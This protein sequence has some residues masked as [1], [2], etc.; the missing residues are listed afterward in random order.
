MSATGASFGMPVPLVSSMCSTLQ[1]QV[2]AYDFIV[3]APT[4]SNA[5]VI[6]SPMSTLVRPASAN[7]MYTKLGVDAPS[8][9]VGSNITIV[10]D[11]RDIFNNSVDT[12]G[13]EC[14][15]MLY[16]GEIQQRFRG[17]QAWKLPCLLKHVQ[18]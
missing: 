7:Y 5:T 2:A 18:Q 12:P 8:L 11:I 9:T 15:L 6:N 13:P 16:T 10:V 1:L 14:T 17:N 3:S 4:T